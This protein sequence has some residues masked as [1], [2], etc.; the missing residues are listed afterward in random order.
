[1]FAELMSARRPKHAAKA[2]EYARI[3]DGEAD[4]LNR[5]V[6]TILDS[7]KIEQGVK[8]Y[9]FRDVDLGKIAS[10]VMDAMEYQLRKQGFNVRFKPHRSP[11][12]VYAD[13]DAVGEAL[14]NLVANSLKYSS[15]HRDLWVKM[16]KRGDR[17]FCTVRDRGCG[18]SRE[19]LPHLFEKFYRDPAF[20]GRIE[21]VGLGLALVKHIVDAHGGSIDVQ[22]TQ[23]KGSMFHIE[24][25]SPRHRDGQKNKNTHRRR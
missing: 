8:T 3:I 25:P 12:P 11:L 24:L 9:N 19:A 22:S 7:A 6:N 15:T 17:V 4:R 2:R 5:L 14:M 1:M 23:G 10:R 20:S 21:G 16:G 18:I 13:P